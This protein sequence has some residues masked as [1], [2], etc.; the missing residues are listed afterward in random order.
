MKK[1]LLSSVALLGLATGAVAAD[2]PSRRA[3]A[4]IIAA[5]PVFTWTGFYVGVNAGIGWATDDTVTIGGVDYAV[6]DD[7]AFVGGAQVGYNY[8]IGSFVLGLE[9][10][11]NYADFGGDDDFDS[12]DWF[13][14]VRARAGV[15]FDRALVYATGGFAFADDANGWTVGGGLEYAF[16]NNLSAKIEGLYVSVEQD[17]PFGDYDADFGVVRAGLNFRFGTY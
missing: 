5:V 14:T 1:I 13:G 3:P 16:T 6:D 7:A 12:E 8:Q 11:I 10:D 4:P 15:A 2:L 9:A 17:T